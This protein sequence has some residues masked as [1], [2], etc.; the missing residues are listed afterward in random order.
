LIGLQE[1]PE[2]SIAKAKTSSFAAEYEL[3]VD[4]GQ[5][6]TAAFRVGRKQVQFREYDLH[7]YQP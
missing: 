7:A 5:A 4:P 3:H 6:R 1:Q 2:A